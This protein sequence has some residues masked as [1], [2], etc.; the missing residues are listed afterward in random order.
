MV[1]GLANHPIGRILRSGGDRAPPTPRGITG[2]ILAVD[3]GSATR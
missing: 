3:G 1:T 2:T